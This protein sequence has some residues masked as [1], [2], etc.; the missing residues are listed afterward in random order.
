MK[1][2]LFYLFLVYISITKVSALEEFDYVITEFNISGSNI[3]ISGKAYPND[4]KNYLYS[5]EVVSKT[6]ETKVFK[7]LETPYII[8]NT[9]KGN[10]LHFNFRM[11]DDYLSPKSSII[12]YQFYLKV[13]DGLTTEIIPLSVLKSQIKNTSSSILKNELTKVGINSSY[14]YSSNNLKSKLTCSNIW[15]DMYFFTGSFESFECQKLNVTGYLMIVTDDY[16]D[17]KLNL[18]DDVVSFEVEVNDYNRGLTYDNTHSNGFIPVY[19]NVNPKNIV[20]NN[21]PALTL[22]LTHNIMVSKSIDEIV[23]DSSLDVIEVVE[24][25]SGADQIIN[26]APNKSITKYLH[27][28]VFI[29]TSI[30]IYIKVKKGGNNEK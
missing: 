14:V 25:K 13:N 29:V 20:T 2:I 4:N 8:K 23:I 3:T 12:D 9:N 6:N 1:K 7:S 10:L 27:M 15:P 22:S 5:L 28:L 19:V 11:I 17:Y 16:T 18:I 30:I 24:I 21:M 26:T